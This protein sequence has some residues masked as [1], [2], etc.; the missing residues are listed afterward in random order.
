MVDR[1]ALEMPCPERDPGFESLALR[2]KGTHFYPNTIKVRCFIPVKKMKKG[3]HP[4]KIEIRPYASEDLDQVLEIW[5]QV[6][7]DGVAFPQTEYL[8]EQT[9]E[10]YFRNQSY[11]G[12]AVEAESGKIVGVYI[13][14]PNNVGRCGHICNA[15]YAVS[16]D[17]RGKG[18]GERLVRHCIATAKEIGFRIL[19]FNAVV[20]TNKAALQLYK[21]L[22]FT[23]LGVI[24]G[25]FRLDDGRY[26][27]I[28]P[29]YIVL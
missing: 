3:V 22:G 27:D 25:G 6:V 17:V 21:K 4:M 19:Q 1:A 16:R 26:E 13:L 12:M 14:H 10:A 11:T 18:I 5:N 20:R 24:P 23:Q 28:V 15:S 29:H 2:H 8:N 7:A 9:G